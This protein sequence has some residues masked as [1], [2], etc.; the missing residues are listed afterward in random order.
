MAGKIYSEG[1]GAA[2]ARLERKK[3]QNLAA[4]PPVVQTAC[5]LESKVRKLKP[6]PW[7]FGLSFGTAV[8]IHG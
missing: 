1:C 6:S 8:A 7:K 2:S 3:N 5:R 4:S